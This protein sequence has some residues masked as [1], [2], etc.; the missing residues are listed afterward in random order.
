M[1]CY[2]IE[3]SLEAVNYGKEKYNGEIDLVQGTSDEFPYKNE[4][5]DIVIL[6]FCLFWVDRKYLLRSVS[7]ADRVLKERGY[8]VIVD[9][10]TSIPYKRENIHNQDM[11]TYKMQYSKLFLA[12][13]QY[14]LCENRKRAYRVHLN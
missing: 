13:P 12:N 10:D 9:F 5:F 3:P 14:F 8:L 2:G 11:R 1:K 6:G 4:K 7:E